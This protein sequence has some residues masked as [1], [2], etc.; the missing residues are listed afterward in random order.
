MTQADQQPLPLSGGGILGEVG[1]GLAGPF[2]MVGATLFWLALFLTGVTLF[3]GLSWI[4]LID[5]TGKLAL[6]FWLTLRELWE[7]I[8][9]YFAGR[10]ALKE[11]EASVA[12][13]KVK[14]ESK[15]S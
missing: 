4:W 6:Q 5:S 7:R 2:N 1:K 3:T 14:K 11:R 13:K 8:N 10:R 9:I 15:R 12:E